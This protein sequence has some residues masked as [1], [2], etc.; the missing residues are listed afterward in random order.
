MGG[1]DLKERAILIGIDGFL[2]NDVDFKFLWANL[3]SWSKADRAENRW[4]PGGSNQS[5]SRSGSFLGSGKAEELKMLVRKHG[6][7]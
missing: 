7:T 3:T 5:Q 1:N 6:R 2:Y 4:P